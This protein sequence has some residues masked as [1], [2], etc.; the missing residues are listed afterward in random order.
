MIAFR[1]RQELSFEA[2]AQLDLAYQDYEL[3]QG[4]PTDE[5]LR[6]LAEAHLDP[7]T[8]IEQTKARSLAVNE[9]VAEFIRLGD[10]A[11]E[12]LRHRLGLCALMG[13]VPLLIALVTAAL[14][15]EGVVVDENSLKLAYVVIGG[16]FVTLVLA[17]V[18]ALHATVEAYVHQWVV[19]RTMIDERD[20]LTSA[21]NDL[22]R[23]D[24]PLGQ[25]LVSHFARYAK[26]SHVMAQIRH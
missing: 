12:R 22:I 26:L 21:I 2:A 15:Y 17:I 1:F 19:R 14:V 20:A 5:V 16:G 3:A 13:C 25:T 6:K 18:F 23:T 10:L 24:K 9:Y 7:T 8:L 4:C 11:P